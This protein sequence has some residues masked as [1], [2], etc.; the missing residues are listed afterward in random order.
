MTKQSMR[1][2]NDRRNKI[3]EHLITSK[4]QTVEELSEHFNVSI[5]TIRRDLI[6]LE[7]EN[8]ILRYHGGAKIIDESVYCP[9]IP[10]KDVKEA[11]AFEAE[12]F[13][14]DG[15][16]IFINTSSTALLI[17]KYLKNKHVTIITNN[18]KAVYADRDPSVNII[19]TGGELRIPKETLIGEFALNNIDKVKADKCFLGCSGI[20]DHLSTSVLQEAAINQAMQENCI[21]KV[22]ILA[23]A[24]KIGRNHSFFSGDIERINC[25]ITDSSADKMQIQAFKQKGIKVIQ[26]ENNKD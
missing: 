8:Q 7:E 21:G 24:Q 19:L 17:L 4:T 11:I 12:K 18:V 9:Y 1:I 14:Q 16:T 15:D 3:I 22:F 6:V 10:Y 26:I 2:V 23:E 25:L 20:S 5:P 13:I